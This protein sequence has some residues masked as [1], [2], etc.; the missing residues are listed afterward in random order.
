LESYTSDTIVV[1]MYSGSYVANSLKQKVVSQKTI[2][3]LPWHYTA[4]VF[5]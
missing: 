5:W 2:F 3:M 1:T 4:I